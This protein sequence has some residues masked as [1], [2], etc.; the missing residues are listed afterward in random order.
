MTAP[1]ILSFTEQEYLLHA[2]EAAMPLRDGRQFF[3]WSQGAL[4]ALLPH[5]IMVCLQFGPQDQLQHVECLHSLML[6]SAKR[7]RLSH[8]DHGLALR[9]A[10]HCRHTEAMLPAMLDL[11]PAAAGSD[12]DVLA[13]FAQE[14]LAEGLDN[15]L[16]HASE[17]LPGGWTC[18][19]LFGL[20]HRPRARQAHFLQLLLPYLH[21]T[22]QRVGLQQAQGHA[23]ALAR[24][25]SARE[26]EIL[27]WVREG[28]SN[29]EIG[30]ILDISGMTVKNHLQRLYRLLGVSNR[31][32]AIARG[33]A[34]QLFEPG[35]TIAR[36][37]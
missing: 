2:I 14:L 1:V 31:A 20:P 16:L 33:M 32:H 26:L 22:L 21:L 27:Y 28:K 3:L 17:R 23:P 9:M 36:A 6:D 4:Q 37:A 8:R 19:V 13:P 24:P 29:E 25:P 7:S 5:R 15:V 10:R 11:A 18:F 12:A 34:L 35:R 30:L